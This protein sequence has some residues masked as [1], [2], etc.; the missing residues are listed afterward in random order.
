MP[1]TTVK[2]PSE[3]LQTLN[4]IEQNNYSGYDPYDILNSKLPL[5]KLG[6]GLLL[7]LHKHTS[8]CLLSINH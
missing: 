3:L 2:L 7:L 8:V 4:Y 6:N 5:L 1:A